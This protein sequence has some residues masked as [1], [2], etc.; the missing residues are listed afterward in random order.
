MRS[1]KIKSVKAREI[2][3]S[4]GN[5][6]VEVKIF[7]DFGVFR[8]SVPSG[9]SKGEREAKELRD[10]GK[11]FFGKGVSKAVVNVNKIIAKALRGESVL[12]QEKIDKLLIDLDG[13]EDK[14]HLGANALLPVSIAVARAAASFQEIS[15]YQYLS[16]LLSFKEDFHLPFASFNILNGGA[17]A[18]NELDVQEFMIIPQE[19][20]FKRNLQMASEIYYSLKETL[21]KSFGK[22][23]TNLGDEGGFAPPLNKTREALEFLRD[24]IRETSYQKEV[25]IGLDCAASHFLKGREYHIDKSSFTSSGLLVFYND[26]LKEFPIIFLEDPYGQDDWQGFEMITKKF[27]KKI[28]IFGD[29][30]TTTN[31]E[32]IKRAGERKACMGVII[33]PNQI[34]TLTETLKAI[35]IARKY[36]LKIMVSHRSGDTCDD[37]IADLAVASRADFIKSGAPARGERVAKY[38]RLLEIEEELLS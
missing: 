20:L 1:S 37:F 18:G 8:S 15:L 35:K 14:S 5:P 23:A 26:L 13:T 2:L 21:R 36:R 22:S 19:K 6:T 31:P 7:T 34:G 28:I 3:D 4:R 12:D 11:R 10:G 33:K 25:K 38:N 32:M 9:A 17:H 16:N 27:R 24:S 30:L 29:D